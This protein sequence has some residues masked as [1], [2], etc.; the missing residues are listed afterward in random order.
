M[1]FSTYKT[2]IVETF[3]HDA[4]GS[5]TFSNMFQ[6][7]GRFS[8]Q[9]VHPYVRSAYGLMVMNDLLLVGV[10]AVQPFTGEYFSTEN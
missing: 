6:W 7:L 9:I 2:I 8:T 1:V 5:H 4:N 3:F 10:G